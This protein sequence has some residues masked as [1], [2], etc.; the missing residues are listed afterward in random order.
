MNQ[1]SKI[2]VCVVAISILLSLG[3]CTDNG[4][5]YHEDICVQLGDRNAEIVIREWEFLLGSGAEI[6]YR[7]NG[8]TTLLGQIAE[9]DGTYC[10][11]Q[12]GK[13]SITVDGNTLLIKWA[14]QHS[15]SKNKWREASFTLPSG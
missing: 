5:D 9:R 14:F 15:D 13:Y 4:R 8:K 7:Q 6:Y 12:N 2:M 11:F 1:I 10:P 3:A